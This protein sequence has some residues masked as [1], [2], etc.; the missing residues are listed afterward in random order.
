MNRATDDLL[1]YR[2]SG[3]RLR[4]PDRARV[5][6]AYTIRYQNTGKDVRFET[7]PWAVFKRDGIWKVRWL[8]RQ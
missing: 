3:Y 6:V 1:E 7:E 5:F 2:L 4:S 8:P